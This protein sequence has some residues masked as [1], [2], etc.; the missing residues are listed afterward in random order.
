MGAPGMGREGLT[1]KDLIYARED[2]GDDDGKEMTTT[3]QYL[4][5]PEKYLATNGYQRACRRMTVPFTCKALRGH[6][7][8]LPGWKW[9]AEK[10]GRV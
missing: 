9:M 8:M 10:Q 4:L 2:Y 5:I 3:R 1:S 7:P 6:Y